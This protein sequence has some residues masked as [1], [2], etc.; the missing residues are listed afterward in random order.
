MLWLFLCMHLVFIGRNTYTLD[1]R[2]EDDTNIFRVFESWPDK[3]V[4]EVWNMKP[5]LFYSCQVHVI[6]AAALTCTV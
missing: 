6:P 4:L 1:A 5:S 3:H 2:H